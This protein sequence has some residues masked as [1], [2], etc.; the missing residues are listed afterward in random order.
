MIFNSLGL[1]ASLLLAALGISLIGAGVL[2]IR[3]AVKEWRYLVTVEESRANYKEC[4][5]KALHAP[6]VALELDRCYLYLKKGELE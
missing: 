6:D 4:I 2:S 1:K 5:D 3:K